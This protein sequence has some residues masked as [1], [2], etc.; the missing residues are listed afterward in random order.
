MSYEIIFYD[1]EKSDPITKF[2]IKCDSKLQAK[3][4]RQLDLLEKYGL[5]IG[6]PHLK[7]V[8]KDLFELRILGKVNIRLILT[9][10]NNIFYVLHIFKKK[11]IKFHQKN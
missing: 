6:M 1:N 2:I 9:Y 8:S 4:I 11:R 3:I 7:K 5:E 10:K